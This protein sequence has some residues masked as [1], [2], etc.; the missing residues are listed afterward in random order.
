VYVF[1]FPVE[2][3]VIPLAVLL[4]GMQVVADRAS[5]V[6]EAWSGAAGSGLHRVRVAVGLGASAALQALSRENR[7]LENRL[8]R[9]EREVASLNRAR[10]ASAASPGSASVVALGRLTHPAEGGQLADQH[11]SMH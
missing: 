4:A 3:V 2:L 7:L 11:G 9:L 5:F 1:P 8:D 6:G 10:K